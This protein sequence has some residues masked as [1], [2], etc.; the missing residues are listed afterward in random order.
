[1]QNNNLRQ[2]AIDFI[3]IF[4]CLTGAFFSGSSFWREYNSTQVKLNEKPVGYIIFKKHVAQR[5][6]ID[7]AVWDR[8]KETSPVYNGD[9]IRTI[10]QSE[11]TVILQ[12]ETTLLNVYESTIIKVFYSSKGEPS[13]DFSGGNIEVASE[14]KN[15]VISSGASTIVVGGQAR[16]N[17][18]EEGFLLSVIDGQ[19]SFNGMEIEA[20]DI[21]ALDSNGEIDTR[22]F[23]NMKSSPSIDRE[24]AGLVTVVFSW[25]TFHFSPDTRVIVEAAIDRGFN[26]IAETRYISGASSVSIPLRKGNYWWRAYPVSSDSLEPVN[27][28]YPSGVLEVVSAVPQV[29]PVMFGKNTEDWDDLDAEAIANNEKILSQIL[30]ILNTNKEYKLRVEGHANSAINPRNASDRLSEFTLELKPLSEMRAKAIM[31][32]LIRLGADPGRLEY[33]GFGGEHPIAAWEDADNWYKNRRV[34]FRFF[35]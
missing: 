9:T 14:N 11:A 7:R 32:Q 3:I 5:K 29:P 24:S 15:V 33:Y 1:M 16:M 20:G 28:F 35:K 21:L 34:E 18:S 31:N 10:E 19:A 4:A 8:L 17:K 23:I 2:K 30:M 6:F 12:D 25:N 22:P 26:Q 27:K 13:I